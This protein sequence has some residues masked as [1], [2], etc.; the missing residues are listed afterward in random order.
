MAGVGLLRGLW[1]GLVQLDFL[2][3]GNW[4]PHGILVLSTLSLIRR[5]WPSLFCVLVYQSIELGFEALEVRL[6]GPKHVGLG[7]RTL[8]PAGVGCPIVL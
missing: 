3:A 1:M 5:W 6:Q 2:F 4:L 7:A 8:G